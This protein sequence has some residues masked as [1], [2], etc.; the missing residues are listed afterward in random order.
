LTIYESY[1]SA[2]E[3]VEEEFS[4]PK[5]RRKQ[6]QVSTPKRQPT[7]A[8]STPVKRSASHIKKALQITPLPMR[9]LSSSMLDSPYKI[10]QANL[11]VSA[12]PSS[13]PCR[14]EEYNTILE[15]LE[16]SIDEGTGAC[17]YVSGVPGT[18]KTA[19]VREVVRSL[20]ERVDAGVFL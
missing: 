13:L 16:L 11:H 14:E 10:A 1:E 4:T 20:N 8:V 12:V 3:S 2:D 7:S 19:T 17:I 9:T 6:S 5:K 18:G 15:Q